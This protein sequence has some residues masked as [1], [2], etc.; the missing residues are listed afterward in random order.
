MSSTR[1]ANAI[2]MG[3]VSSAPVNAASLE[4][5]FYR[6]HGSMSDPGGQAAVLSALPNALSHLL[7]ALQGLLLHVDELRLYGLSPCRA[8][9]LSRE[10][11][12]VAERLRRILDSNP[13]ALTVQRPPTER[14]PATCRDFALLLTACLRERGRAARVRCGFADYF[15]PGRYEDHWACE[16]WDES[17]GGWHLAD[18]QLDAAH[19]AHF[20][21]GFDPAQLPDGAFLNAGQAWRAWRQGRVDAA[22][23]GH[24][25]ATGAP[26]LLINVARDRLALA[27]QET[28]AW[29]GWRA[30][31][32]WADGLDAALLADGDALADA[33][34]GIDGGTAAP[35]SLAKQGLPGSPFWL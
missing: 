17:G 7:E 4:R 31:L 33:I 20:R 2:A 12:P 25:T 15:A 5:S 13:A 16:Y 3:E 9:G 8:S 14:A 18:A 22:R 1:D 21:I 10:T 29:D 24:G 26:M 30:S 32:P 34:V 28:S 27:K 6:S 11:L 23:F 19:R 35:E